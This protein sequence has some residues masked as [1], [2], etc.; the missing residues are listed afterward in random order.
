MFLTVVYRILSINKYLIMMENMTEK[1]TWILG[2]V[3]GFSLLYLTKKYFAGGVCKIRKDLSGKVAIITGGNTGIGKA[4]AKQLVEM[5]CLVI[6]GARDSNK[7]KATTDELNS[8]KKGEAIA[9]QLD[10]SKRDSIDEFCIKVKNVLRGR[11]INYLINN[12]GT[13]MVKNHT[14]TA[15]G[16]EIQ[17]GVNHLGHFLLTYSLWKELKEAGNPRIINVSSGAHVWRSQICHINFDDLGFE[18]DPYS[19]VAAYSRSKKANILFTK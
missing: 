19:P 5:G 18:R 10:L 8:L 4:T 15:E 11:P 3:G 6:I 13:I 2:I 12:S 16:A 7:N 14:K 9:F 1:Q 17:M